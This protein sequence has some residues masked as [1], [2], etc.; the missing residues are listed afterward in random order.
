[1]TNVGISVTYHPFLGVLLS[2]VVNDGQF[3]PQ[4][5]LY[6]TIDLRKSGILSFVENI[7]SIL[8]GIKTRLTLTSSS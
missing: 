3:H 7:L 2:W 1:M 4:T 6:A 5:N 8:Y